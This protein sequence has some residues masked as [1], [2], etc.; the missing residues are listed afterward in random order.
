MHFPYSDFSNAA[1]R[2]LACSPPCLSCCSGIMTPNVVPP[3]FTRLKGLNVSVDEQRGTFS[4]QLSTDL[5][6]A[7]QVYYALYRCVREWRR[8]EEGRGDC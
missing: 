6:R 7:G 1:L 8:G 5:A 2:C 4:L 3:T